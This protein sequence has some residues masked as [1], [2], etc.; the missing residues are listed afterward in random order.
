MILVRTY[1]CYAAEVKKKLQ[2]CTQ[3][4]TSATPSFGKKEE[5]KEKQA[6][7]TE[8]KTIRE[9]TVMSCLRLPTLLSTSAAK[10]KKER[11]RLSTWLTDWLKV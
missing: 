1:S 2:L 5:L 4:R 9:S 11:K 3:E 10:D 7:L 8:L 6:P